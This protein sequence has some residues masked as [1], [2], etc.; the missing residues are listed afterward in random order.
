[1]HRT[2][3]VINNELVT[4][5]LE[6]SFVDRD[7]YG[8]DDESSNNDSELYLMD[9][10]YSLIPL[11]DFR[12]EVLRDEGSAVD[13]LKQIA[14]LTSGIFFVHKGKGY[15]VNRNFGIG[16]KNILDESKIKDMKRRLLVKK[17]DCV[18]VGTQ[19]YPDS[20]S[21][22]SL[23]K[24]PLEIKHKWYISAAVERWIARTWWQFINNLDE[25]RTFKYRNDPDKYLLPGNY[26]DYDG[27][28]WMVTKSVFNPYNW[29]FNI[30]AVRWVGYEGN[31]NPI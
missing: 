4:G 14:L 26:F 3:D 11:A 28:S 13:L 16:R 7:S 24:Y 9:G 6:W 21:S 18:K 5:M 31:N 8:N 15:F 17:Y 10:F 1:M 22:S 29:M 25:E 30:K 20:N 2:L 12:I 19:Y 27:K 23:N